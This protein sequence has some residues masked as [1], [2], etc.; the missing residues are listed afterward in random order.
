MA[1]STDLCHNE[2]DKILNE[3]D[4]TVFAIEFFLLFYLF[5]L[6][7]MNTINY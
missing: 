7:Q 4:P 3:P 5:H 2:T 1:K 6:S